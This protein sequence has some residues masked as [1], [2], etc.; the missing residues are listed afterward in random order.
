MI[1]A[2]AGG[3]GGCMPRSVIF[4]RTI[5]SLP[6]KRGGSFTGGSLTGGGG[7]LCA[8]RAPQFP[9]KRSSAFT[10]L[11]Q[12]GHCAIWLPLSSRY[13]NTKCKPV[14]ARMEYNVSTPQDVAQRRKEAR[15]FVVGS[16]RDANVTRQTPTRERV[17]S[18]TV[19]HE[20]RG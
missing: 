15:V 8:I 20:R 14:S 13:L 18:K 11:W 16:E 6:V 12:F 2:S 9:Q 4:G 7:M 19:I 1:V 17:H 3:A 5:V 10:S